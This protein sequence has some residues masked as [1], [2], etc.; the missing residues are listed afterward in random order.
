MRKNQRRDGRNGAKRVRTACILGLLGLLC[1]LTCYCLLPPVF[2]QRP[3]RARAPKESRQEQADSEQ[4]GREDPTAQQAQS[5]EVAAFRKKIIN[6]TFQSNG[7]TLKGWLYKPEGAGPFPA[8]IWNHGSEQKPVPHLALAYF[9][10]TH[11]YVLFLPVRR[12]HDPSPGDY[13]SDLLDKYKAEGH[14]QEEVREYFV[15]LQEQENA[16]VVAAVGWLKQQPFVDT[17]KM[18]VTGVSYGGIQTLLTAQKGLGLR[19]AVPFSPGSK[20]W[21]NPKLQQREEEAV[22]RAPMP[23]FLLQAANDWSTGPSQVLGPIITAKGGLNRAKLYPA[24]GTTH[25]EGHGGFGD[26]Q[27][28]TEIWGPDVLNFLRAAG[29]APNLTP[30][31]QRVR[32]SAPAEP[33]IPPQ[34]VEDFETTLDRTTTSGE[35]VAFNVASYLVEPSPAEPQY[36]RQSP[37]GAD[38]AGGVRGRLIFMAR[39]GGAPRPSSW[40]VTV[41]G[42]SE[43]PDERGNYAVGSLS[44]GTYK[45]KAEG[46]DPC[47]HMVS[48]YSVTIRANRTSTL[49]IYLRRSC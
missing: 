24:F 32:G 16:D 31:P 35:T 7:L 39:A 20:S 44:P 26:S 8:I 5:P 14:T 38:T 22:R 11:G 41:G 27:Q 40:T 15:K 34:T 49:N 10:V 6:V 9:Y 47:Y 2:A 12:G 18:A 1:A 43:H 30:S 23:L 42:I 46:G 25:Q 36:K 48:R 19:A 28:G 3:A 21:A 37:H 33:P 13:L 29:V 17:N 4:D 45:V